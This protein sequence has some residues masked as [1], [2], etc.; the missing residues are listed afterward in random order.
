MFEA[1]AGACERLGLK[2]RRYFRKKEGGYEVSVYSVK[3]G[4]WLKSLT[5]ERVKELLADEEA[6]KAF[7]RGYFDSDGCATM[8]A[9]EECRNNIMFG[10]PDPSLLTLVAKVCSD[11][12]IETSVYGPYRKNG[13]TD[14][15]TLYVHARSKRRF[16]EIIG[17]SLARKREALEK[18]ARFYS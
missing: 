15:H 3:L 16:S 11:L 7:V 5:Y 8:S 18:I 2:P 1:F 17:S 14:M 10:D 4:R 13:K 6:K 9:I 12:G